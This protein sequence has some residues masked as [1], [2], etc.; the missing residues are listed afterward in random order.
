MTRAAVKTV[1]EGH[2]SVVLCDVTSKVTGLVS[3][4]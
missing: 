2:L 4:A 1:R 3:T